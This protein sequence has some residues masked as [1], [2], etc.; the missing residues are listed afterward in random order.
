MITREEIL[1]KKAEYVFPCVMTYY[2]EPLI[3]DHARGCHLWDIDGR[4]YLDFF[5]GILT[6]GVGHCNPKVTSRIKDQTDRLQHCSTVYPTEAMVGLAEKLAE[7]T[8]GRIQ[9][10]FL[11]NSDTSPD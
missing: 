10:S 9:K 2:A 7:I 4:E 8:P 5:G 6:V 11:T 1:K 3:A